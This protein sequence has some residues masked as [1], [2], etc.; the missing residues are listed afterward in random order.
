MNQTLREILKDPF[1][2][3]SEKKIQQVH[4]RFYSKTPSDISTKRTTTNQP[5]PYATT[6]NQ[7]LPYMATVTPTRIIS[8]RLCDRLRLGE[9]QPILFSNT[10]LI[11][12]NPNQSQPNTITV[13]LIQ[14]LCYVYP[15]YLSIPITTL[16]IPIPKDSSFFATLIDWYKKSRANLLFYLKNKLSPDLPMA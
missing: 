1:E 5:P 3:L 2:V 8:R 7:P 14:L 13:T 9:P 11:P 10:N 4:A 12:L 6:T 15:S 16:G